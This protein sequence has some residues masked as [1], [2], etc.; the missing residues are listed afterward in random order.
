MGEKIVW[1]KITGLRELQNALEECRDGVGKQILKQALGAGG[2]VVCDA[3]VAEAPKETGFLSE[4]FNKKIRTRGETVGSIFI[5]PKGKVDYPNLD[6]KYVKKMNSR[7]KMYKAGRISVAS[8][9]RFLEFGTTK[10]K[11]NPFMTRAWEAVKSNAMNAMIDK[12]RE[13]LDRVTR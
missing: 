13:A 3:M 11:K 6:G 5:G 9:A 4:H 1:V 8:V 12:L 2:D 7:G 10:M